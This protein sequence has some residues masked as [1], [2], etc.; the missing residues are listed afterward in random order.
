[1]ID[2][3]ARVA[4]TAGTAVEMVEAATAVVAIWQEA[5]VVAVMIWGLLGGEETAMA[6]D[7][8]EGASVDGS[9]VGKEV[10]STGDAVFPAAATAVSLSYRSGWQWSG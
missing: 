7:L 8:E 10:A 6:V 5:I 9:M 3:L 2:E 4:A 1:M